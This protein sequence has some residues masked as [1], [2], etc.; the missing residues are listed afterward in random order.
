[1]SNNSKKGENVNDIEIGYKENDFEE[2]K[3]NKEATYKMPSSYLIFDA[4]SSVFINKNNLI[5]QIQLTLYSSNNT[6]SSIS[7][8]SS[9][10]LPLIEEITV[11]IIKNLQM[12]NCKN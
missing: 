3:I 5:T 10:T 2:I 6:N 12:I 7:L 11:D 9:N 8:A 4:K 1:M